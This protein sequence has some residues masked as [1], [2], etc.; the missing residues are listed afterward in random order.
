MVTRVDVSLWRRRYSISRDRSEVLTVTRTAPAFASA[1]CRTIHSAGDQA[2]FL[3]ER[4]ERP[5]QVAV[6]IDEGFVVG[7]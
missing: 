7:Q 1:N 6:G 2:R 4:L 3:F 5:S